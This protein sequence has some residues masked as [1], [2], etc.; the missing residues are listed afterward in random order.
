MI[1]DRFEDLEPHQIGNIYYEDDAPLKDVRVSTLRKVLYWVLVLF[2]LL[3]LLGSF[4]KIPRVI[5]VDFLIKGGLNEYI[6]KFEEPIFIMQK[7]VQ[8]GESVRVSS[9][10]LTIKSKHIAALLSELESAKRALKIHHTLGRHKLAQDSML[11]KLKIEEINIEIESKK[12]ELK[13]LQMLYQSRY[14]EA[15]LNASNKQVEFSRDSILS[16]N[17]AISIADYEKK[18]WERDVE[19]TRLNTVIS[20]HIYNRGNIENEIDLLK[21]QLNQKNKDIKLLKM[22]YD[23][24]SDQMRSNT[25]KIHDQIQY[26]YGNYAIDKGGIV[27]LSP[28]NGSIS[29][30]NESEKTLISDGSLLKIET[31]K[32]DFKGIISLTPSQAPKIHQGQTLRLKFDAYPHYTWGSIEGVVTSIS[33]SPADDGN[34]LAEI[35]LTSKTDF[36]GTIQKG[37]TGEVVFIIDQRSMFSYFFEKVQQ[38]LT[39]VT[40]QS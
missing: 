9:P 40:G 23:L 11:V 17:Q 1:E 27:L 39:E 12:R 33:R 22:Q 15:K 37:G 35:D 26:L 25:Q 19:I 6:I 2:L 5:K 14:Y 31:N 16:T 30:L 10:L 34:F 18:R 21:Q 4:V 36:K 7:H 8:P 20:E 38:T 24:I 3:I 32:E 29:Y 28:H 13:A